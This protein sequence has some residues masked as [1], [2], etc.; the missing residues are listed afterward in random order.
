L[1]ILNYSHG[2]DIGGQ[3]I[4]IKQA[5]DRH[6]DHSYRSA[7]GRINYLRYPRDLDKRRCKPWTFD[8]LHVNERFRQLPD[9]PS[10]VHY[11]GTKFRRNP[12]AFLV[13]RRERNAV[14]LVATLDLWLLAPDETEWLPAPYNL[15]WLRGFR[16]EASGPAL[17]IG[18]A[19]TDRP[20]KSTEA[21]LEA[22]DRLAETHAV[23]LVL[24]ERKPWQKCLEQ[25]GTVDVFFDQVLLGYGN[26]AIEAWGMGIPVIAGGQPDTLA[27]MRN[28]FGQ[29]PFYEATEDT[30]FKALHDMADGAVRAEYAKR[31]LDHVRRFHDETLVVRQLEAAY[32]QTHERE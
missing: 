16:K 31:G 25:K 5:F 9:V 30:I 18:H 27:E 6:S 24:I 21:F 20:T 14:G 17:R 10:V 11:H 32:H 12:E 1:N 22:V 7:V 13:E 29:L 2:A 26:N 28:R 23:E 15:E 4:R 3:A 19:P 8:V